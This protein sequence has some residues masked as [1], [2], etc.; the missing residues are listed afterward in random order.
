MTATLKPR[1][2]RMVDGE[3]DGDSDGS[4]MPDGDGEGTPNPIDDGSSG[5]ALSFL[6]D[7]RLGQQ[8]QADTER[9][10]DAKTGGGHTD[11]VDDDAEATLDF[12]QSDLG[13]EQAANDE[14]AV[15]DAQGGGHTDP[16]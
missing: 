13:K 15:D 6:T 10:V 12:L 8:E 16:D 9:G 3:G 14:K 4:D 1:I 5:P 2:C 7:G 11:P